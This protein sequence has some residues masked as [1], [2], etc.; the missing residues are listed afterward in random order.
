MGDKYKIEKEKTYRIGFIVSNVTEGIVKIVK[1][2]VIFG[3]AVYAFKSISVLSGN[4]TDANF[5][6]KVIADLKMNQWF[7]YFFGIG[8]ITYGGYQ[9][10]L[11]NKNI[12]R[13]GNENSKLMKII[14]S[15]KGTSGLE[16]DGSSNWR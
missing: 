8:G 10:N 2:L 6:L 3:I 7:G 1:Y 13:T 16:I 14:D 9:K 4:S 12:S 5:V 11:R 15:N